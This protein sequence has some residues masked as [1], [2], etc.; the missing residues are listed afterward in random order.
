MK[1]KIQKIALIIWLICSVIGCLAIITLAIIK[2]TEDNTV[3]K[4]YE[5]GL[6]ELDL[7]YDDDNH[8]YIVY[9]GSEDKGTLKQYYVKL[10]D[11]VLIPD[12]DNEVH[13]E[14]T[15]SGKCKLYFFIKWEV[16]E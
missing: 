12:V 7:E 6:D 3:V 13:F 5:N 11:V 8:Q 4:V 16:E 2:N 15:K 9:V 1:K 14:I 10:E